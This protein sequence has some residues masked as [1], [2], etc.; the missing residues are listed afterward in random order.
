MTQQ[1]IWEVRERDYV[2]EQALAQA[3][4]VP[5]LMAAVLRQ[6][7]LGDIHRAKI[8]LQPPFTGLY[9]PFLLADM[10][11][12]VERVLAA[13]EEG[14]QILVHG[15]YD[16]DGV[17]STA[18]LV[19]ALSKLG[20]N[21]RYFIPHRQHDHYG[22][23]ERAIRGAAREGIKLLIAADCGVC[24]FAAVALA[25]QLGQDVIVLDHHHPGECLPAGALV[26]NPKR[27][28][29]AYP[30]PELTAVGIAYKFICALCQRLDIA[31]EA[32][33]R[34]FLDL[35]CIGTI[36]DVAPLVDEN[37]V[38]CAH[39][40]RLLPHTKKAGLRAL[41]DISAV[42]GA[43][44][45]LDVAYRLAPRLNAVG[46]MGDATDALELLLASDEDEALKLALSL[47]A[48]NRQRQREQEKTYQE[49]K[50]QAERLLAEEDPPLLMLS[51]SDWHVGIVG[52]VAAKLLEEY[53]RPVIVLVEDE[54]L[55][56]GSGRSI[57]GFHLAH[58]FI[59]CRDL[60]ERAGG[61]ELAGG[62]T[63]R[64]E[65]FPAVKQRLY[66]LAAEALSWADLVP[67][68]ELDAQAEPEEITPELAQALQ[69]LEPCGQAN[70]AP[71]FYTPQ[72]EVVSFRPVGRDNN[73]LKL[74]VAAGARAFE[75]IGFGLGQE[76]RWLRQGMRIDL[77]H[78]PE[79]NAFNGGV[80]LQLRI[81]AIRPARTP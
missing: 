40:L 39:G 8:F 68:L 47:E 20:I 55:Y 5:P 63:F 9:D 24:D 4:G 14:E 10:E 79:L 25:Q 37:R 31:E 65:N 77:A 19:R 56:T 67:R 30:F 80:G 2:F 13:Q 48:L 45:A 81:T 72:M 15:D 17:T 52:I 49:A 35:V 1:N 59:A 70:P 73:H 43:L 44:S 23:S 76:A 21:V 33:A 53:G 27:E 16:A 69:A 62:L 18:L 41:L 60:L 38:F 71:L 36:A 74:I 29:S 11:P 64:R 54:E 78:T 46:R 6:R 51:H 12:A 3:L 22:L 7:G 57:P 75:A 26:V 66:E 58:A 61:H 28:D 42:N 32:A 34:A 50:R